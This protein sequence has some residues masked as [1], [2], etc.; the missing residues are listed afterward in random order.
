[1]QFSCFWEV[2]LYAICGVAQHLHRILWR[3][4]QRVDTQRAVLV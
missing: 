1:M 2:V 3:H 4:G